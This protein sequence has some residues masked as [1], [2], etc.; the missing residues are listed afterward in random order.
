MKNLIYPLIT[1]SALFLIF[2]CGD[3]DDS[4]VDL[5]TTIENYL[6]SN[7]S[8]YE[9]DESAMEKDCNGNDVYEV[10]IEN[11]DDD[12]LEL[13]FDSEGNLIYTETEI[14][15]SDLPT[16]VNSSISSNYSTYSADEAERL[17]MAD[18]SIRYEVELEGTDPELEVIFEADGTVVCEEEDTDD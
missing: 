17:N 12:E 15:L 6:T 1:L 11:S 16:E 7:Y 2:S 9:V 13:T 14:N 8:D 3:D 18:G 5:P 10:E 4:M